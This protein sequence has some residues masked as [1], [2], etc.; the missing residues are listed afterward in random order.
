MCKFTRKLYQLCILHVIVDVVENI[1]RCTFSC[2]RLGCVSLA[3][4]WRRNQTELLQEMIDCGINAIIIKT[5][6]LG[7]D[8][9]IHLG[10]TIA[11]IKPHLVKSVCLFSFSIELLHSAPQPF[12]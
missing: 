9:D 2:A 3:Y 12:C 11:E 8:P 4:L 6:S 10:Q 1:S 5:A 7:L